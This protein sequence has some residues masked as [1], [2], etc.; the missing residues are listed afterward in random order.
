MELHNRLQHNLNL[1]VGR[2]IT[3]TNKFELSIAAE[4]VYTHFFSKRPTPSEYLA[5][6][7][8]LPPM[9]NCSLITKR[10]A[11]WD[12]ERMGLKA[13]DFNKNLIKARIADDAPFAFCGTN[14][15]P[16]LALNCK[17]YEKEDKIQPYSR[18]AHSHLLVQEL[19]RLLEANS[20][21]ICEVLESLYIRRKGNID[22]KIRDTL[23]GV[24]FGDG[25]LYQDIYSD[26]VVAKD[27]EGLDS[28]SIAL[29]TS[30]DAIYVK[31]TWYVLPNV[32]YMRVLRNIVD[33]E[34]EFRYKQA[35]RILH[36]RN[37]VQSF[38]TTIENS[39]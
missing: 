31:G 27:F 19:M 8:V 36:W 9:Q 35:K 3:A 22:N 4:T 23:K 1:F 7:P 15:Q 5:F 14:L 38:L 24:E 32:N 6:D 20:S 26:V 37:L 29:I 10:A 2:T 21:H 25:S 33:M 18:D 16:I 34:A 11:S 30:I 13:T 28:S 12:L 39:K 17:A